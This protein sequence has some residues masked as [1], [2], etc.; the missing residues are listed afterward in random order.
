M[1]L[2]D[3]QQ[4]I[5]GITVDGKWGP[6]TYRAI[7]FALRAPVLRAKLLDLKLTPHFTLREMI[8]SSNQMRDWA[9][10]N[11]PGTSQLQALVFLC[12]KILEPV[13]AKFGP[14][15]VT[16]GFRIWTPSSQHGSG[17]AVDFEVTGVPNRTIAVWIRDNLTFDQLIL[18]AWQPRDPNSGWIHASAKRGRAR[19]SVLHTPTGRAP[20]FSGLGPES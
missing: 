14:V 13:R 5:G 11:I 10:R 1:E 12:E 9:T 4:L 19:M 16:S 18:E 15:R 20:Y 7:A 3:A 17:E 6:Q 2:R 8:F